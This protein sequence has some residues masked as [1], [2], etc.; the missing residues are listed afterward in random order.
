MKIIVG[1][2]NPGKHYEQTRHNVGWLFLNWLILDLGLKIEDFKLE[3]VFDAMILDVDYQ[4]RLL[5]VKPQTFMNDSGK[6]VNAIGEFY[7]LDFQKE[8]LVIH[9]DTDLPLG[10]IKLTKS[11]SSAGHNGVAD[12]IHHLG[13]QN[14]H[15]IRVGVET[16]PTKTDL[17]TE[18]FVLQNFTADE[19]EKLQKEIF[20]K[21]KSEMEAF[22]KNWKL[23]IGN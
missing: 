21:I 18:A 1:L 17:P 14:F 7:K 10:K 11:S 5:L 22:I 20:P 13:T 4:D 15:R 3:K 16:R 6:A 12:I 19:I 23:E 9:D 8:L 2:G